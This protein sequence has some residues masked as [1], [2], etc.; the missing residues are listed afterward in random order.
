MLITRWNE[1]SWALPVLTLKSNNLDRWPNDWVLQ[2]T[3]VQCQTNLLLNF[4]LSGK[5]VVKEG[6]TQTGVG[7]YFHPNWFFTQL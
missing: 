2:N 5:V 3:S 1:A 4:H 7:Y 6:G